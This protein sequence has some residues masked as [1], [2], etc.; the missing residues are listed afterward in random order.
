VQAVKVVFIICAMITNI[1]CLALIAFGV[2]GCSEGHNVYG[3]AVFFGA[4]LVQTLTLTTRG[5]KR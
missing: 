1:A 2:H 4:T 3:W 5:E